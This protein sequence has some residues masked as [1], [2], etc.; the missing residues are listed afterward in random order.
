MRLIHTADWH[1]GRIFHGVHLT[2]EARARA[3]WCRSGALR[4][5]GPPACG[6]VGRTGP[7]G[8]TV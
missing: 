5:P 6:G 2:H 4:A 1:L 8:S 3:K 7:D